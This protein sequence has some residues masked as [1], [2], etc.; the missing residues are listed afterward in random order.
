VPSLNKDAV[1]ALAA[2]RGTDGPVVSLYLDV[3]GQRYPRARDYE[4][5]LEHLLRQIR[6]KQ[7]AAD[8]RQITEY[9]RANLDRSR[10]RGLA[11]FS[12][13]SH[14]FFQ[15][16][17][18]PVAVRNQVVRNQAP[19]VHQLE[20]LLERHERFGVL[21]VDKQ[22]ARMLVFE[23]GQLA[24]KSELFDE[25]PRHDDDKGDWDKDHV[26]DHASAVAQQHLRR[27]AQV[28]LRVHQEHAL[29][30]LILAGPGPTVK[31]QERELHDYLRQRIVARLRLPTTAGDEQIRSA[32]L[33]VE[34]DIA[35]QRDAELVRRLRDA[36]GT[37]AGDRL[38]TGREGAATP[39]GRGTGAG[40]A[41]LE[42]VLPAL[43]EA[44]VDTLLV[45]DGYEASGWRCPDCD[46]L[47]TLGRRCPRCG[48][49]MVALDDV[50][51]EAV[52]AAM[53]QAARIAIVRENA[54]LDV[55]GRIGA[56]LRF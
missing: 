47:A 31:S 11:L 3:D 16:F 13:A 55:L 56:L 28:A 18:L 6:D 37:A 27:A 43:A 9:V 49:D 4:V 1:K 8:A 41:G 48:T 33:A 20:G 40:V 36:V 46:R 23:L 42:L 24:D 12:C 19:H 10:T 21:I 22:R 2:F 17:E 34:D 15:A 35:R 45:S 50:V 7:T 30:H 53:A 54:D 39:I 44:R 14:G 29:D 52:A 51:E 26:R 5:R 38:A 32:A 25:L